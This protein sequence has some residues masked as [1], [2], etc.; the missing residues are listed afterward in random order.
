MRP[1]RHGWRGRSGGGGVSVGRLVGPLPEGHDWLLTTGIV[2]AAV[3]FSFGSAMLISSLLSYAESG[4]VESFIVGD[5]WLNARPVVFL[6]AVALVVAPVIE[7][8]LFRGVV[9][10][11]FAV[12]WGLGPAIVV[13]SL[14]FGILHVNFVGVGVLGVV[15][16]LLY[17]RTQTL[18]VP[19]A[20][21]VLNNAV[22]VSL[23]ILAMLT[24]AAGEEQAALASAQ[25]REV[26]IVGVGPVA[27]VGP[28]AR[29]LRL[30]KL[31]EGRSPPSLLHRRV[32]ESPRPLIVV[33]RVEVQADHRVVDLHLV[34]LAVMP[35]EDLS[36]P[37]PLLRCAGQFLP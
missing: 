33:G 4:W 2:A 26:I 21:H 13:S 15:M 31:A 1:L 6:L 18:I 19:I 37:L 24:N 5:D 32:V 12:K 30:H 17:V 16:A 35:A 14:L 3:V 7:E 11:R 8:V 10:H 28:R 22:A 29:L 25:A 36:D 9:L 27:A 20:C 34:H 23:V